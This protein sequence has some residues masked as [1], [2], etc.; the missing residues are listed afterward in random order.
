MPQI[1]PIRDLKNTSAISTLCHESD[2]PIFVTKNGYGDMVLMSMEM[3]EKNLFLSNV[4]GKLEV[5]ESELKN[6]KFS[7]AEDAVARIRNKHGI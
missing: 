6:G 1:L 7:S 4:Y 2:E 5:A 3:Y